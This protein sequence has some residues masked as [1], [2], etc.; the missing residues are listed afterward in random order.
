MR[1]KV[2]EVC[3]PR[4]PGEPRQVDVVVDEG[5]PGSWG[6][7]DVYCIYVPGIRPKFRVETVNVRPTG[8]CSMTQRGRY[9]LV[10]VEMMTHV[11]S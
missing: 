7:N 11:S 10:I 8:T 5:R 2:S 9:L 6:T 1:T 4:S 3:V